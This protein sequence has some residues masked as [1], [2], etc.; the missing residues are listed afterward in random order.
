M[1]GEAAANDMVNHLKRIRASLKDQEGPHI[2]TIVVDGENAWENYDNDGKEF[3]HTLYNLLAN[4]ENLITI[5]P[6]EYLELFPEQRELDRL[7][8][9]AWFSA[10]YDT[11]YG[12]KRKKPKPGIS[13]GG[14][15]VW[16]WQRRNL[17]KLTRQTRI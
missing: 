5:T 1:S 3:F 12:G 10:N 15:C 8:P 7:F 13:W 14:G 9:G 17:A 16:I 6:S 11:W 2:V 4:D